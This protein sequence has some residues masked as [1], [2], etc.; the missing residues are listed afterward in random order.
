M[1]ARSNVAAESTERELVITRVVN[2]P[3]EMVWKALTEPERLEHWWGPKGFTAHVHKLELRPGGIFLYSQHS[4]DGRVMWGRWVYREIVAPELLVS[5]Q[6]FSDEKGNPTRNPMIANWPLETLATSTFTERQG[7]TTIVV[8]MVPVNATELERKT[9]ADSLN[10]M[11]EGFDGTFAKLDN[12]L[13][14]L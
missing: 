11:E 5:V 2:A 9:F 3:R 10:F 8:R 12:Y 14:T 4:A 7:K 1:A 13:A 6:S